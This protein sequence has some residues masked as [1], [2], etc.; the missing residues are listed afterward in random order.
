ML[1]F[2]SEEPDHVTVLAVHTTS[3]RGTAERVTHRCWG[4]QP[5]DLRQGHA[6]IIWRALDGQDEGVLV[7]VMLDDVV[8]HVHQD[9]GEEEK[10]HEESTDSWLERREC[11]FSHVRQTQRGFF[12][13]EPLA[14]HQWINSLTLFC[15]SGKLWL[16]RRAPRTSLRSGRERKEDV[17]TRWSRIRALPSGIMR[18]LLSLHLLPPSVRWGLGRAASGHRKLHHTPSSRT[19]ALAGRNEM[20]LQSNEQDVSGLK[21]KKKK[22]SKW[23]WTQTFPL[24]FHLEPLELRWTGA[25]LSRTWHSFH[26]DASETCKQTLFSNWEETPLEGF[27]GPLGP[28][29]ILLIIHYVCDGASKLIY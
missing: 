12:M 7:G 16:C 17:A 13:Q 8:V 9:A 5:S 21:K 18:P 2:S 11:C 25:F 10:H 15:F 29:M 19:A 28:Q 22:R 14:S 24:L 3:V 1:R 23:Q 4:Q 6:Q 26:Q 27:Y 20:E